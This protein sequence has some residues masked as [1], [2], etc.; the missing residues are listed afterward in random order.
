MIISLNNVYKL[1]TDNQ[2]KSAKIYEGDTD[3]RPFENINKD[4]SD[5]LINRLKEL[6][7]IISGK[8]TILLGKG[9]TG[10]QKRNMT[11]VKTEFYETVIETSPINLNGTEYYENSS[12]LNEKVDKMVRDRLLEMEKD[13]KIQE[14]EN[15]LK[16]VDNLGGKLNYFLTGFITKFM[17]TSTNPNMNGFENNNVGDTTSTTDRLKKEEDLDQMEIDLTYIV[18]YLGTD[19][20]NKFAEKIRNGKADSVKPII[21]NFLNN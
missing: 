15:K 6:E 12:L 21:I 14:L 8:F 5:Q 20:I 13:H 1:I 7:S 16:E 11:E 2:Y 10:E 18:D 3:L 17:E 19:N 9:T 4:T